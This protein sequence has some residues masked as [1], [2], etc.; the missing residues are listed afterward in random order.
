MEE[1]AVWRQSIRGE[2]EGGDCGGVGLAK[3]VSVGPLFELYV[4]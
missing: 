1:L 2:E 3:V 4:S